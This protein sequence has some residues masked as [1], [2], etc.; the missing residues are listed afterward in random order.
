MTPESTNDISSMLH[1][2]SD[3]AATGNDEYFGTSLREPLAHLDEATLRILHDLERSGSGLVETLE[4]R[5]EAMQ[6]TFMLH[7]LSC[8]KEQLLDFDERIL[9]YLSHTG[10]LVVESNEQDAEKLCRIISEH[11]SLQKYF[12]TMAKIAL[13]AHGLSVASHAQCAL[14]TS[15]ENDDATVFSRYRMCL[16]GSLSHFYVR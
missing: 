11:P 15:T 3:R 14:K 13:L 9:L 4:L 8:L 5:L 2:Q 12:H 6:E 10:A 16:K 7:L 1:M